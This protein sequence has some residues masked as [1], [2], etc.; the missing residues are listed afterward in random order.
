MYILI[1]QTTREP[2]RGARH[3]DAKQIPWH[4]WDERII[5]LRLLAATSNKKA[6]I[7][8]ATDADCGVLLFTQEPG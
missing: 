6:I 2:R 3:K 1:G 8:A 5:D 4:R 7:K